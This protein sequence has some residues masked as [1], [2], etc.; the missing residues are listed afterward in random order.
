MTKVLP[1]LFLVFALVS[2]SKQQEEG[3]YVELSLENKENLNS[4]VLFNPNIKTIEECEASIEG[5]VPSIMA[6]A[7]KGIPRDSTV[8][9]WKCSLTDPRKDYKKLKS[10]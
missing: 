4:Y 8:T 9:G 2:C 5:A 7:P 1:I 10:S 3:V 6:N